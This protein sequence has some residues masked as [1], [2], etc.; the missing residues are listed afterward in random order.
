MLSSMQRVPLSNVRTMSHKFS[1]NQRVKL[2]SETS[3]QKPSPDGLYDI[4]RL[5]PQ[6]QDGQYTYRLKS[7][8]GERIASESTLTSI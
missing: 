1:L 4:I 6:S 5:L 3:I 7:S 2:L 8:A